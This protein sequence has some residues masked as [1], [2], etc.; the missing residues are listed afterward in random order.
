MAI[1]ARTGHGMSDVPAE[2]V[3]QVRSNI[4]LVSV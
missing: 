4:R 2:V 1:H 3:D